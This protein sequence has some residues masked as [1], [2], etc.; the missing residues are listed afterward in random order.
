MLKHLGRRSRLII[1]Q[2]GAWGRIML[3]SEVNTYREPSL[4]TQ[5]QILGQHRLGD[6]R[7]PSIQIST[8]PQRWR[9]S[10]LCQTNIYSGSVKGQLVFR[11]HTVDQIQ[12]LAW[13]LKMIKRPSGWHLQPTRTGQP[14][15][16]FKIENCSDES[17]K[18][19]T[20]RSV[21]W[22][23]SQ[24]VTM[25]SSPF[26]E[27]MRGRKT[28]RRQQVGAESYPLAPAIGASGHAQDSCLFLADHEVTEDAGSMPSTLLYSGNFEGFV[29]KNQL[30]EV[31]LVG[32]IENFYRGWR[33]SNFD[34]PVAM[35]S[36]SQRVDRSQSRESS[37]CQEPHIISVP[38]LPAKNVQFWSQQR[39]EQPTLI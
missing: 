20:R 7:K 9:I 25:M 29:Q 37:I 19:S 3:F 12:T 8:A 15:L 27:T 33:Q 5:R 6:F 2:Y 28:V 31:Q 38:S 24:Q 32:Q 11:I 1:F 26:K 34:T 21:C 36:Y 14:S 10:L 23:M 13:S 30:N 17:V 4:D 39:W 16:V 35:I 22:Q 18:W